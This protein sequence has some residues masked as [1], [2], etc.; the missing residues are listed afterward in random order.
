MTYNRPSTIPSFAENVSFGERG[1]YG[2]GGNVRFFGE[3]DSVAELAE[4]LIWSRNQR[5][6]IALMGSG[7]NILFSDRDFAGMVMFV[8]S[9]LQGFRK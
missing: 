2:I 8:P 6:P 7:S 1:Y 4:L 5:L 3:P 9:L